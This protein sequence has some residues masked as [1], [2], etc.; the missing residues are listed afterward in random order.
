[1]RVVLELENLH[2]GTVGAIAADLGYEAEVQEQRGRHVSHYLL[3]VGSGS[4][5]AHT[6]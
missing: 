3:F 4:G 5:V 2:A 1:M 6:P